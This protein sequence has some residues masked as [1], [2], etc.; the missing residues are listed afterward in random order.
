LAGRGVRGGNSSPAQTQV[1]ACTLN[2]NSAKRGSSTQNARARHIK[3]HCIVSSPTQLD[4]ATL[5]TSEQQ[6]NQLS[7][8]MGRRGSQIIR[9][10]FFQLSWQN[11]TPFSPNHVHAF[12]QAGH[13]HSRKSYGSGCTQ[14]SGCES[15]TQWVTFSRHCGSWESCMQKS[16]AA[17]KMRACGRTSE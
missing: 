12:E 11:P 17:V 15:Q 4:C 3:T 10:C 2:F 7:R 13:A 14:Y 8:I 5:E 1:R 6:P 16:R 9:I